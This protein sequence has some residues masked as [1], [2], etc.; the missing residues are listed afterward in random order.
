MTTARTEEPT[1][2]KPLRLW[3]GVV[4]VVLLLLARFGLKAVIPGFRGFSLGMMWSFGAAAAVVFWWMFFSRAR[5]ADRLGAIVLMLAALGTT[6]ALR[7]ESMGP[8]WLFAYAIPTLC[9]ALVA[10]AAAGG[11]LP[12][13]PRRA[14]MAVTIVL[15]CGV[16]TLVRTEGI[17]GDH[18]AQFGWRWAKSPEE[19]LLAQASSEPA[20]RSA[21]PSA[22]TPREPAPAPARHPFQSFWS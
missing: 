13:G 22:D 2:R 7:H 4:A 5:W 15:A 12:D 9:L 16:W 18:V 8:F 21:A 20:A 14:T 11:R 19:R 17:T 6:W 10:G 1:P 3:P